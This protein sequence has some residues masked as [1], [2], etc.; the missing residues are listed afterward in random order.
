MVELR[1]VPPFQVPVIVVVNKVD[2][3]SKNRLLATLAQVEQLLKECRKIPME[4]LNQ[5]DA[6]TA[7]QNLDSGTVCP[8][9]MTSCMTGIGLNLLYAFLNV[10]PTRHSVK[11]RECLM[12]LSTFFQVR[13]PGLPSIE[14]ENRN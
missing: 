5:D 7:A 1:F 10:L 12:Q 8:I 4:I 13:G 6:L 3:V 11:E 2:T 14:Q 9:F